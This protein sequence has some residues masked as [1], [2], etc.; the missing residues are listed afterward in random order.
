MGLQPHRCRES[1]RCLVPQAPGFTELPL[2][3]GAKEAVNHVEMD[4]G[5]RLSVYTSGPAPSNPSEI[6]S[7]RRVRQL[8]EDMGSHYDYVIVDSAPIPP[9]SDSV[10]PAGSVDGVLVVA[11][12]VGPPRPTCWRRWSDSTVWAHSFSGSCSTRRASPPMAS[13][14]AAT[15]RVR[16]RTRLLLPRMNR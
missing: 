1:T 5:N 2:G 7:V 11:H 3:T 14:H 13:M 12:A 4:T 8:F 16:R 15:R 10:A 9:V 6:L